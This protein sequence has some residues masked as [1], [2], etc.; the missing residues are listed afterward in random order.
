ME[1]SLKRYAP[2]A[3][4]LGLAGLVVAAVIWLLQRQFDTPVQ[5]FLAV[6]LL[7]LAL[8]MLMNPAAVQ[9]WLGGRQARYGGNVLVMTLALLGILS[10]VNYLVVKNPQQWDLSEGQINT[11][12]PETLETLKQLPAPV[13]VIGFYTSAFASSQSSAQ[14]LLERYKTRSDGKFSYE[15][16]DPEVEPELARQYDITQNGTLV[17]EL[18]EA[19]E[20]LTFATE[21]DV[22]GALVRLTHPT[23]RVIYFLAG[24][25]ER[26]TASTEG[27]GISKV[28]E[29][30]QNQNYDI[31]PLNLQV[32]TT[33]PADMR[34][35]V[36][37]G[38]L[39][40]VAADEVNLIRGYVD[41]GGALLVMLD[42]LVETETDLNAGEPLADY[43]QVSWG[44]GVGRDIIVDFYNAAFIN[45]QAQPLVPFSYSY[46]AGQITNR[47]QNIPT[48]FRVARSV[49]KPEAGEAFPDIT[50]TPLVNVHPQAW[51]ETNFD[52]L[53]DQAG[54][55]QDSDDTAAPMY[56]GLAAE[57]TTTKARLVVFGDSDFA[58][59]AF[60]EQ[61][62]NANLVANSLNW[63]TVEESLINLTPKIPTTRSLGLMDALS[64]NL[65]FLIT[66]VVMPLVV[67]VL[68]GVVWFQRRRHA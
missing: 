42:P 5:A 67:L 20:E 38:P 27:D 33:V 29:V 39:V 14:D 60:A 25:G 50:Y 41:S 7:G 55:A 36:I 48:V 66:V 62:A 6:G 37:A 19:R 23:S 57:N 64:V 54:P 45:N 4:I 10:L 16:H 13:Y 11:L 30:L 24:H 3:L 26:D 47:L 43:L 9:V 35:L 51:G 34:A 1:S 17:L 22:T 58:V 8:A 59:N 31:R 21:E 28:V 40:P 2:L 32:T 63:A 56:L 15:F 53:S 46:G 52:S 44:I 65:I 61:G 18:G 49:S 12:A 68:G